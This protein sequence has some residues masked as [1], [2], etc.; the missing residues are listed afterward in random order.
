MTALWLDTAP[1]GRP[2]PEADAPADADVIVIGAGITGITTALRLQEAGARTILLEAGRIA[3]GVSGQTTAKVTTQHGLVYADLADA[4]GAEAARRYAVANERAL[5][6]I[7]ARVEGRGIDCGWR[8]RDAYAYVSEPEARERLEAEAHAACAAGLRATVI[9]DPPLPYAVAGALRFDDQAELDPRRYLLALADQLVAAG[10][11]IHEH[12]RAVEVSEDDRL[13]VKTPGARLTAGHVVVATHVPFPDRSLAFARITPMRSYLIAC[14]IAG[15][16]PAGM[17]ISADGPTRSLRGVPVEDGELLLVGG[18]GHRTGDHDAATPER[19]DRLEAFARAHWDV[20]AVTHRWSS[21]DAMPLDGLPLVG[22][23][24]PRSERLLLATGFAK[25]G[26]TNG[27]A[28]A[29]LLADL[30]Q[31]RANASAQLFNPFRVSPRALPAAVREGAG[32]AWRLV[33]DRR[34]GGDRGVDD[35]APGD[36][37][38]V[39]DGGE[40][41]AAHRREDGSLVAVSPRCTHLGCEVRWNAAESSWDCPCHGSRFSPEGEVLHGPAVHRLESRPR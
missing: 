17:H 32:N 7:A 12:S 11:A 39:E 26:M 4:H 16:P 13:T 33:A 14:R 21:Q 9:D 27:T 10:G 40:R 15:A 35:L 1:P 5:D 29:E 8:R 36:G 2:Y 22:R 19:F 37:A 3:C 28:A 18:E 6:W 34:R 41:V 31:G 20:Q 30:V 25:W 24:T 38:I 23:A